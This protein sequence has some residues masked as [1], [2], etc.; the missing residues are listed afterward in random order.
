VAVPD[1][2]GFSFIQ[3][4]GHFCAPYPRKIH[5]VDFYSLSATLTKHARFLSHDHTIHRALNGK[6]PISKSMANKTRK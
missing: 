1:S 4:R 6:P 3:A 5:I 2:P